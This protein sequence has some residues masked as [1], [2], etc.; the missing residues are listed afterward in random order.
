MSLFSYLQASPL[1]FTL[2]AALFGLLIGSFLN[3]VAYRLPRMMERDWRTQCR[4]LLNLNPESAEPAF[5]LIQPGSRCPHCDHPVRWYQNIPVL[6]YLYLGGRCAACRESI[7]IRYP[8]VE[9]IAGALAAI[10]AWHFGFGLAALF[11]AVLSWGLLAL[12]LIDFD[13]KFLPD[14]ITLPLLWLGLG[15]NLFGMYTSLHAAVLGAICGYGILWLVFQAFRLLPARKAWA[16]VIS[17]YW[18]CSAPGWAG[19]CCQ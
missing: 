3:V 16:T 1:A 14:D 9:L 5:N 13:T 12:A 15:V 19:T 10:S 8:I 2:C 18:P 11:A 17:N 6:S 7:S 4:E